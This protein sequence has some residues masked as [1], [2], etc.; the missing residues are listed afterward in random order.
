MALVRFDI[1]TIMH[2]SIWGVSTQAPDDAGLEL[3]HK[4]KN[5][6]VFTDAGNNSCA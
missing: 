1:E 6:C 4:E 3:T 5:C 2:N